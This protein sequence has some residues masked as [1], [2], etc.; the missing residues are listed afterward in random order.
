VSGE[1]GPTDA[2]Y[3]SDEEII[4]LL[5]KVGMCFVGK[6]NVHAL[7]DFSLN[8]HK[9]EFIC[10]LGPSGCGKSTLLSII[11]G[12]YPATEGCVQIEGKPIIGMDWR[13]AIM[14]QMPHCIPG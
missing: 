8:V 9:G 11:A 13:R 6:Q 7:S 3:K 4:L 14:F 12:I 1:I 5:E 2:F 10:I